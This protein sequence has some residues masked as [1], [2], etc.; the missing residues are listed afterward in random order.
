MKH[1]SIAGILYLCGQGVRLQLLR[2]Y[3]IVAGVLLAGFR[4]GLPFTKFKEKER[5][6]MKDS[7]KLVPSFEEQLL[8]K[9]T[10]LIGHPKKMI[11]YLGVKTPVPM[12]SSFLTA[13][14]I[15]D[16]T[17]GYLRQWEDSINT[18]TMFMLE[19]QKRFLTSAFVD[20]NIRDHF[21]GYELQD[22]LGIKRRVAELRATEA[23]QEYD[24]RNCFDLCWAIA[25]LKKHSTCVV[26]DAEQFIKAMSGAI[27]EMENL[28]IFK[29]KDFLEACNYE[30][31]KGKSLVIC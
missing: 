31:P 2:R 30:I 8:V 15:E 18:L 1:P 4:I 12:F 3:P 14:Q 23:S 24:S 10:E 25:M 22:S 11:K 13:E 5:K 21:R 17:N 28:K 9:Q 7:K 20:V 16:V 27:V 19:E 6:P 26:G 29:A